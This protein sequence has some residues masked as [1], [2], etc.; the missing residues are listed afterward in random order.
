[1]VKYLILALLL[2]FVSL[3]LTPVVRTLALRLGAVDRP[4]E[5]KIHSESIPRLGGV[6]V[7]L[8]LLAG[9]LIADALAGTGERF[10]PLDVKALVPILSSAMLVFAA[11]VWDDI[12]PMSVGVKFLCQAVAVGVAIWLGVR[13]EILVFLRDRSV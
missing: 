4:S 6:A 7:F 12:R 13:I 2:S 1:M 5:R 8:A 3:V 11:G 9:L 10:I